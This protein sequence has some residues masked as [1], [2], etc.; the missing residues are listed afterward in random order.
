IASPPVATLRMLDVLDPPAGILVDKDTT[1]SFM[2]EGDRRDHEQYHCGIGDLFV[3][4]ARP[5][6]RVRRV[7]VQ[8]TAPPYTLHEERTAPLAWFD[9]VITRTD[10]PFDPAY[11][12]ATQILGLVDP[13]TT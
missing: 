7:R 5:A 1:F 2:L 4:H 8:R 13:R 9:V 11:Y 6:A 12:F 3:E 10:R